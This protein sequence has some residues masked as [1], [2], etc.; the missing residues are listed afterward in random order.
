LAKKVRAK[1]HTVK[2]RVERLIE[3]GIIQGFYTVIDYSKLGF[4]SF[5]FYFKVSRLSPEKKAELI[6]FLKNHKNIS[7]FYRI[8]GHYDFSFSIWVRDVWD[9]EAFW[10]EFNAKFGRYLGDHHLAIKTSYTEFGRNYFCEQC[11]EKTQFTVSRKSQVELL[12]KTDLKL[13][14]LLS[15]N[16]RTSLVDLSNQIKTSIVTCRSRIKNLIKKRVIVGFR[17]MLDYGKLGYQY[18]KVDLWFADDTKKQELTQRVL[19]HPNVIYTEKTVL[20]SDFEFDLEV[21]GFS[22]FIA[23]MDEFECQFP[24]SIG[25]YEYYTLV[26][27]YKTNY[28]PSI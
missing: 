14:T 7:I 9:Y 15:T 27:N 17:T 25:R 8:T 5:R 16:S 6:L 26:K 1:K 18:Y 19:S 22:D 4:L 12:D 24:G 2:Y 10:G 21:R 23:I 28:L 3:N 20:T 11:D 13:L